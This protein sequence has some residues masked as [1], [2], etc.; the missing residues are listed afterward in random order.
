MQTFPA[1]VQLLTRCFNSLFTHLKNYSGQ[2]NVHMALGHW[3]NT[4]MFSFNTHCILK[5]YKYNFKNQLAVGKVIKTL[6]KW[7]TEERTLNISGQ[8]G[9]TQLP[10]HSTVRPKAPLCPGAR[11]G[12]VFLP[13]LPTALETSQSSGGGEVAVPKERSLPPPA[14]GRTHVQEIEG[15][16][17]KIIKNEL[18]KRAGSK[19]HIQK[20]TDCSTLLKI[21]NGYI[22]S[23][24]RLVYWKLWNII[25]KNFKDLNKWKGVPCSWVGRCNIVR[26]A[27]LSSFTYNSRQLLQIAAAFIKLI[28]WPKVPEEMHNGPERCWG[29]R[30][31][32]RILS[33]G[34]QD[35]CKASGIKTV[36]TGMRTDIQIMGQNQG[37]RNKPLH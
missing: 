22:F 18:S 6:N 26:R 9:K 24:V 31:K 2:T 8:L 21:W 5:Q 34:S 23:S 7:G 16:H 30:M 33:T 36:G 4:A 11:Q 32:R 14:E 17:Q 19:A 37:S 25:E 15:I 12:C 20:P 10:S 1:L 35:N 27:V 3:C 28:S 13:S 29:R